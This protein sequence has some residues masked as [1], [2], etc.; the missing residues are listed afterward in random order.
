MRHSDGP[1][2]QRWQRD[3]HAEPGS[4]GNGRRLE[5]ELPSGCL[6]AVQAP[7]AVGTL[8]SHHW[9]PEASCNIPDMLP[10]V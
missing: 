3:P 6:R 4:V 7:R 9:F 1:E 10:R 5:V 8:W 2:V